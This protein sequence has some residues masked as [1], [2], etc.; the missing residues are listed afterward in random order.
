MPVRMAT[1]PSILC[2]L[3]PQPRSPV[4]ASVDGHELRESQIFYGGHLGSEKRSLR[5]ENSLP[6]CIYNV[7][8]I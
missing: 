6:W 2:L 5:Y 3:C 4:I 8:T 1:D 7:N